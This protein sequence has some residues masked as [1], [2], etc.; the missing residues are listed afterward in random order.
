MQGVNC[1]VLEIP[2]THVEE[3]QELQ[4]NVSEKEDKISGIENPMAEEQEKG[5]HLPVILVVEDNQDML[6]FI[7]KQL[8]SAYSVLKAKDGV[9]ALE[10]LEDANIDLL[11]SDVMMPRM[12]GMELCHRLK[13]DLTYSHIPIVLLTAKTNLESKIED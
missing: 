2:V 11:I 6:T 4:E 9:E 3:V 13:T 7:A 12:D 1:F 10:I 8:S 5:T